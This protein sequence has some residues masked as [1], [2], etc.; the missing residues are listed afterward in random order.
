MA[1]LIVCADDYGLS[2]G[3]SRVIRDL[4]SA[5]RLTA[6]SCMTTLP[7]WRTEAQRLAPLAGKAD[8]GLHFTLTELAPLEPVPGLAPDGRFPSLSSLMR[9][10]FLGKVSADEVRAELTAQLDAFEDAFGRA[11]DYLDG[12]QHVHVLP[13]IRRVVLDVFSQRLARHGAYLRYPGDNLSSIFRR[14]AGLPRGLVLYVLGDPLRREALRR[15]IAVNDAM[16]GLYD[17]TDRVPYAELFPRFLK[18]IRGKTILLCHPGEVDE[19]LLERDELTGQRIIEKDYF[20]STAY[21]EAVAASGARLS[22]F[23]EPDRV[24]ESGAKS[25]AV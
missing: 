14:R 11:P 19:K 17:F 1:Q 6:T 22:R 8:I 13:T 10:S 3:V 9:M 4:I 2:P 21:M 20:D 23:H 5:G 12:H 15:G 24:L 25:H 18:G 16:T 7:E